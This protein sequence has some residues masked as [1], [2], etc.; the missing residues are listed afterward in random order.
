MKP[1]RV[2]AAVLNQTPLDWAGN[3]ERIRAAIDQARSLGASV[4]CLPE[5]CISGYGCED[6]F[7]APHVAETALRV[8]RELQAETTGMAVTLGLPLVYRRAVLNAVCL[9]V[10]GRARAFAAK[11]HLARDGIHYEPRWFRPWPRGAR[12]TVAFDGRPVPLGD[13]VLDCQG[14]RIGFEICQDAWTADRPAVD[15]A[16]RGVDLIL[17]PSASHFALGKAEVRRR[18]VQEASRAFG[19][20]YIYA[21]LLGNEAGRAIYD[22]GALIAAAGRLLAIGPRFS[23]A[24]VQVTSAV[25]DL[26]ALRLEQTDAARMRAEADQVAGG[27]VPVDFTPPAAKPAAAAPEPPEWESAADQAAEEFTRAEALGLF[28]YLRKSRAQGF[29]VSLSGGADSAACACLVAAMVRLAHAELGPALMLAKLPGGERFHGDAG[30]AELLAGLLTC[31]YQATA[32][33]SRTTRQAAA[34]LARALGARHHEI[35]L[36]PVVQAY[37]ERIQTAEGRELTWERDDVALQNI[38]ARVRAPSAWLLANLSRSLLLATS[39][40]SEAAVGYATMDGDTCGG[41][42]PVAGIDKSFIRRWLRWMEHSG[43]VG[44]EPIPALAAVNAQQ[45]TAELR[46][47]AAG[48]TDE[49]DLMPYPVLTAIEDAAIRD[50][51]DPSAVLTLLEDAFDEHPP[52]Q[53]GRWVERFFVLWARNQWKRER[54]APSFHLDDHNLDPRSWCRFPILSGGF[55]RELDALRQRLRR[56]EGG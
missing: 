15:L 41:L 43:P 3:A 5:L 23:F 25:V 46:P 29:V 1:I 27:A 11:R 28:D 16:A 8:L 31:V 50:R 47:P 34:E 40:R 38:Q 4:L 39:N 6:A 26:D 42:S 51:R 53:L 35:D 22:G 52:Q 55:E 10:D 19:V 21:N 56:P 2:A 24:D 32:N 44:L 49:D 13:V 30:V 12:S 7:L 17:N 14:L 45:P 33:S 20:A 37:L 36:E 9:M 54:F 48:Q 18:V